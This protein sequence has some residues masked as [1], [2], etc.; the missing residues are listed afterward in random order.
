VLTLELTDWQLDELADRVAARLAGLIDV[1]EPQVELVAPATAS[2]PQLVDA[3][4]LARVLGVA[5]STVYEHADEWGGVRLGGGSKP[6]LR[7]DPE[8]ARAAMVGSTSTRS[9][10]ADHQAAQDDQPSTPARRGPRMPARLP[11]PSSVLPITPLK[12]GR[13]RTSSVRSSAG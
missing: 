11:Q 2:A 12:S 7:F 13:P 6:R 5:R 9:D 3:V 4:E 1:A 10:S 8:R